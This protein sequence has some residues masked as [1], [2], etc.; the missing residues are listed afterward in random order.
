VVFPLLGF[1]TALVG[2]L[3]VT[4]RDNMSVAFSAVGG[5]LKSRITFKEKKT[6]RYFEIVSDI[7]NFTETFAK[8]SLHRNL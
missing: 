1:C 8:E 4:F 2:R 7:F 6:M 3:L 5:C